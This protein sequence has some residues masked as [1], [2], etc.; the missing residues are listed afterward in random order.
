M[1]ISIFRSSELVDILSKEVFSL[2]DVFSVL[3]IHRTLIKIVLGCSLSLGIVYYVMAPEEYKSD[4]TLLIEVP[5]GQGSALS[6]LAGLAGVSLP[7][8]MGANSPVIISADLYPV[9]LDSDRFLMQVLEQKF[10]FEEYGEMKLKEYFNELKPVHPW[11]KIVPF[12][13]GL[14]KRVSRVFSDETNSVLSGIDAETMKDDS[15]II[16]MDASTRYAVSILRSRIELKTEPRIL[17]F[18]VKMPEASVSAKLNAVV[19]EHLI[20]Y[21]TKYETDKEKENV[22]FISSRLAE[23]S[24]S[25][26]KAQVELAEYRDSNQGVISEKRRTIEEMLV[27]ELNL[28]RSIFNTMYGDLEQSRIKLKSITPLFTTIDAP[29][30]PHKKAEPDILSSLI[31]SLVLGVLVTIV[32]IFIRLTVIHLKS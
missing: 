4:A 1:R 22:N 2:R 6:G 32:L 12:I 7:G 19:Q 26:R 20:D 18:S 25:L 28:R 10:S 8:G 9:I 27:A 17:T 30:V 31:L 23:S 24:I 11:K 21:V 13:V 29:R 15:T 14:P 5:T 3:V 16:E